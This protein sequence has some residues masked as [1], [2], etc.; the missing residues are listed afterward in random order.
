MC[1]CKLSSKPVSQHVVHSFRTVV[2]DIGADIGI[3]ISAKGFQRGA[4]AAAAMTNIRLLPWDEFQQTFEN[5]WTTAKIAE[6]D[7]HAARV[8]ACTKEMPGLPNA[9]MKRPEYIKDLIQSE[10][11]AFPIMADW[12]IKKR[13]IQEWPPPGTPPIGTPFSDFPSRHDFFE[14]RLRWM[15]GLADRAEA[16][17]Q[18]WTEYSFTNL[19][20]L[21][22]PA[23]L[24]FEEAAAALQ[25]QWRSS[26]ES[27]RISTS[28]AVHLP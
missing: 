17:L 26:G 22:G 6:V 23:S 2:A 13:S 21:G 24:S 20:L 25:F 15:T 27:F 1:E 16:L 4:V 7:R 12:Y 9:A 19:E 8:V 18:K 5:R 28:M 14:A 10:D 3:I 11:E